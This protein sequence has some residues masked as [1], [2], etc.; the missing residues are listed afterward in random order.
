MSQEEQQKML[1]DG[2]IIYLPYD[3]EFA[4]SR[5]SSL[6]SSDGDTSRYSNTSTDWGNDLLDRLKASQAKA[7]AMIC[8]RSNQKS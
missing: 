1:L 8:D 2:E 4:S 5:S 6:S 3:K 7:V